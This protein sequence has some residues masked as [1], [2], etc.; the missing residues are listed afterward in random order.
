MAAPRRFFP[1]SPADIGKILTAMHMF[2]T[3][4]NPMVPLKMM[5]YGRHTDLSGGHIEIQYGD[6]MTSFPMTPCPSPH[7][8]LL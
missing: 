4:D 6:R 5:S 7:G 8:K 2:S 1:I 3:M